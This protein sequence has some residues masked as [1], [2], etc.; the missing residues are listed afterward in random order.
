M[1]SKINIS[2]DRMNIWDRECVWWECKHGTN[3]CW[4]SMHR[5]IHRE[6]IDNDGGHE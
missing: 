2:Y 1:E 4:C 3:K 6:Y 5:E